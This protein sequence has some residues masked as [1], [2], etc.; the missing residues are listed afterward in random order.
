MKNLD[1]ALET[2]KKLSE[3]PNIVATKEASGDISFI[4]KIASASFEELKIL[5]SNSCK[6]ELLLQISFK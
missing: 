2:Y 1:F 6:N 4:A 3:I 5:C